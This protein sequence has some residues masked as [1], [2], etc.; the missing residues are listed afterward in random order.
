M[1]LKNLILSE[2]TCAQKYKYYNCHLCGSQRL[3][4]NIY[5]HIY[6]SGNEKRPMWSEQRDCK[7]GVKKTT[8]PSRKGDWSKRIKQGSGQGEERRI[9]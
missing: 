4:V 1:E 3:A 2:V 6:K 9:N 8:G 5:K 7:G